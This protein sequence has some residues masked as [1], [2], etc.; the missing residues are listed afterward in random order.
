MNTLLLDSLYTLD[1]VTCLEGTVSA[2]I[3]FDKDH[4]IFKGHFPGMP[5]VPGVCEIQML[6]EIL[7]HVLHHNLLLQSASSVKYLAVIDPRV[8]PSINVSISYTKSENVQSYQM[9]AQYSYAEKVFMKFKGVY[10]LR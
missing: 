9:S 10:T 3:T 4:D 8:H 2:S 6:G 5:V 7:G 1:T